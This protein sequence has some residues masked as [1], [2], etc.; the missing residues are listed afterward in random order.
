MWTQ[1]FTDN[2]FDW[3][4]DGCNRI[5]VLGQ[6]HKQHVGTTNTLRVSS[7]AERHYA[8]YPH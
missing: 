3:L 1:W 7:T 2:G 6:R 5:T 4:L 8:S